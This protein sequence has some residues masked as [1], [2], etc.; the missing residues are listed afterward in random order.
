MDLFSVIWDWRQHKAI[1][2]AQD[3]LQTANLSIDSLRDRLVEAHD[4]LDESDL[5]TLALWEL[6]SERL[7]VTV[8][9][10][11]AKV[12][13]IDLRDGIQDGKYS[14]DVPKCS[15]CGRK[16]SPSRT[17]CLSC[18]DPRPALGLGDVLGG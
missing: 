10:L 12:A 9:Q 7:G 11:R 15:G 4:R 17:H 13:E 6:L 16:L 2:N 14:G 8:E 1:R 3:K 18:G 5:I